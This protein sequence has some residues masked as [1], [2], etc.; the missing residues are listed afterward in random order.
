L[1]FL[2]MGRGRLSLSGNTHLGRMASQTIVVC[3]SKG[4]WNHLP[5]GPVPVLQARVTP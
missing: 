5:D 1:M 4:R 3:S 2:G